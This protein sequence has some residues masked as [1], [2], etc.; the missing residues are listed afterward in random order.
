MTSEFKIVTQA[1]VNLII[2]FE[3]NNYGVEKRY[4]KDVIIKDFKNKLE[5]ITGLSAVDMKLKL[6]N[7]EK[8]FVCD[9]D[10]D[11]KMLG[12]YPAE[13]NYYLHVDAKQS[14]IATTEDPNFKRFELTNEEYASKKNT[15]RE[16]KAKMKLGQFAPGADALAQKK[17][18]EKREKIE[19]E[20]KLLDAIS[21]GARCQ[22][23]SPGQP[24]R[25]G[26]V[27]FTGEMENKIGYWVG[28]KYDEPLG[29]NDGSAD[30]KRYFECS[31]K[32]GGFV[33]P[34]FIVVGDFPEEDLFDEI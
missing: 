23:N 7:K 18:E 1:Y 19:K 33:K 9:L 10:D 31:P 22:V 5:M 24:T 30:G 15:V 3:G 12:F 34:E 32:Y 21:I 25:L 13:D 20:K 29:K 27:M 26:T 2:T 16:F 8:Q 6:L 17:E 14:I 4:S 11:E 28:V